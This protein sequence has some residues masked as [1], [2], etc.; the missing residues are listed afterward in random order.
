MRHERFGG[1]YSWNLVVSYFEI[2]SAEFI[3][4]V[5]N[6]CRNTRNEFRAP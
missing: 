4:R 5:F 6:I 3:P 1:K 2:R